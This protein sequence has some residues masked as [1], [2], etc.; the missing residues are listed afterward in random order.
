MINVEITK[1]AEDM[2]TIAFNP[3]QRHGKSASGKTTIVATTNGFVQ[4]P[5]GNGLMVSVNV[6]VPK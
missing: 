5:G 2:V 3:I 1:T 4:V 6:V